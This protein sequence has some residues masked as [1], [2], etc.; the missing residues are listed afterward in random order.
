MQAKFISKFK[1]HLTRK[2][3][4]CQPFSKFTLL[5]LKCPSCQ[6]IKRMTRVRN[7]GRSITQLLLLAM[8]VCWHLLQAIKSKIGLFL[9]IIPSTKKFLTIFSEYCF[10][11]Q[12][13]SQN[14]I[15]LLTFEIL[16]STPKTDLFSPVLRHPMRFN[17]SN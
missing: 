14:F 17:Y 5:F 4:I 2:S 13:I 16:P 7:F 11:N 6:W 8:V 10:I 12:S 15:L 1:Q 9:S 3:L